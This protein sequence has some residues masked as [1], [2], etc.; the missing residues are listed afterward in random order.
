MEL[1]KGQT[2]WQYFKTG[3]SKKEVH[4]VLYCLMKTL[5]KL[6]LTN[7]IHNDL[8]MDNIMIQKDKN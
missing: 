4:K 1:C 6:H 5:P 8:K 7:V 2:L 3:P